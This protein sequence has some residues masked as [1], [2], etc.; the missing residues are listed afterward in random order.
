MH[1][2][3]TSEA[4]TSDHS[5]S[6]AF[7]L[8]STSS[9][10]EEHSTFST[11][12]GITVRPFKM[13][14]T[15]RYATPESPIFSVT[16]PRSSIEGLKRA[17]HPFNEPVTIAIVLAVI[18]G[19][20]GTILLIYYLISLVTKKSSVDIQ[21]HKSEDTDMPLHPIEQTIT[22]EEHADV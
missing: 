12:L 17:E 5:P 2:N 1:E 21:P 15:V 7:P 18:A 13:S 14:S 4:P 9:Y 22:Q 8:P 20:I 16:T 6:A 3:I 11:E 10:Q 19:I